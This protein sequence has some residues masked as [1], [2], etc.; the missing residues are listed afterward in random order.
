MAGP[1]PTTPTSRCRI[2]NP[3]G[4]ASYLRGS[5]Q[6]LASDGDRSIERHAPH[7]PRERHEAKPA[8]PSRDRRSSRMVGFTSRPAAAG[9]RS[10][11]EA[12]RRDDIAP[13]SDE[14]VL[15][16][17]A[18]GFAAVTVPERRPVGATGGDRGE[19]NYMDQAP[20]HRS[21]GWQRGRATSFL[22]GRGRRARPAR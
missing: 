18:I 7:A 13:A 5:P 1:I 3:L 10:G 21:F 14:E 4:V 8:V 17:D 9:Q 11:D 19:A 12:Q 16:A 6:S 20:G 22:R 2:A 15:P